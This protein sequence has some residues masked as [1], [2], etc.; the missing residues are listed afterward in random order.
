MKNRIEQ[1]IGRSQMYIVIVELTCTE[2]W[3]FEVRIRVVAELT[4]LILIKCACADYEQVSIECTSI[5]PNKNC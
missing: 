3:S 1:I 2:A 4:K 5:I